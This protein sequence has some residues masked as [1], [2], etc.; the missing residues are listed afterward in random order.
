MPLALAYI[1]FVL[2]LQL[3]WQDFLHIRQQKKAV[4]IGL[5]SQLFI[6]PLVG[7]LLVSLFIH[8]PM[9]SVGVMLLSFCAG[10]V[11]S[12]LLSYY[13]GGNVALSVT[14]TAFSSLICVLLLPFWLT[15]I[16]PYFLGTSI[17]P[18]NPTKIGLSLTVLSI[19]PVLVGM[20]LRHFFYQKIQ[21]II[22]ILKK[23][24]NI[25]FVFIV[26]LAVIS[27]WQL[28]INQFLQ[29]GL[30]VLFMASVLL[31]WGIMISKFANLSTSLQKTIAI[32]TSLQNG[33]MGIAIAPLIL[34]ATTGLPAI[35]VPSAVYGVLMN[36]VV[37]PYVFWCWKQ[38]HTKVY[39]Y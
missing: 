37:L 20:T 32:E 18:I 6:V 21:P 38:Q 28:M 3:N 8:D 25:L 23:L 22:S 13:A 7:F 15:I 16:I 36:V 27:N 31:V 30:L 19:L 39:Q 12:N 17:P 1:M 9:V 26:L 35:A 2:G 14:L 4:F 33:A 11:T 5:F 34:P 24:M 29:I 10:G